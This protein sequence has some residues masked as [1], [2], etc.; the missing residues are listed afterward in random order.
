MNETRLCSALIHRQLDEADHGLAH[1]S[2]HV[3][4]SIEKCARILSSPL[5]RHSIVRKALALPDWRLVVDFA[6]TANQF[7]SEWN[8]TQHHSTLSCLSRA[9]ARIRSDLIVPP[10]LKSRDG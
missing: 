5:I 9:V 3:N 7:L 1:K 10:V 4:A 8:L 2:S 6:D